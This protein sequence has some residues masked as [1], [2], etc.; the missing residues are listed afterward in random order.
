MSLTNFCTN[1]GEKLISKSKFCPSCGFSTNTLKS[2]ND[3]DS[4]YISRKKSRGFA[5]LFTFLLPGSGNYYIGR[6]NQKSKIIL[7]VNIFFYVGAFVA[8]TSLPLLIWLPSFL[9]LGPTIL[10]ETDEINGSNG[11]I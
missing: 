5:L 10:A 9:L 7:G 3:A 1:C 2:E 6:P 8:G 11:L 4:Q